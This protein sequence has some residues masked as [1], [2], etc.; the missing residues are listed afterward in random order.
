MKHTC[1][2][3]ITFHG[4]HLLN[5]I[6]EMV[7]IEALEPLS[8]VEL[9]QAVTDIMV[10]HY[11]KLKIEGTD[12][13]CIFEIWEHLNDGIKLIYP[14]HKETKIIRDLIYGNHILKNFDPYKNNIDN[15]LLTV[16]YLDFLFERSS[17]ENASYQRMLSTEFPGHPQPHEPE[18]DQI[19]EVGICDKDWAKIPER[20]HLVHG[21]TH[22]NKF[23]RFI[24]HV[25]ENYDIP[26]AVL[27]LEVDRIKP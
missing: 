4:N 15:A 17:D 23:N 12:Q 18:W 22:I 8:Q 5:P 20:L 24:E 10:L 2:V 16:L 25:R 27:K 19:E 26:K 11:P 13:P 6:L 7:T 14:V 9:T 21:I 3:L 1:N